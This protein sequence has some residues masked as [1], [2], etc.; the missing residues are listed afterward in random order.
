MNVWH[1]FSR[2]LLAALL[3]LLA[4]A[5]DVSA[6][7][8]AAGSPTICE[9]V[10]LP[11]STADGVRLEAAILD[12]T[13]DCS[14]EACL[15][16]S[17]HTYQLRNTSRGQGAYLQVGIPAAS[18]GGCREDPDVA[19]RDADGTEQ[20][21]LEGNAEYPTI[22]QVQLG[23]GGSRRLT[24]SY[25]RNL[26]STR[27][28]D[29][30]WRSARLGAWGAI[31]GVH[32]V[33][34]LPAALSDECLLDVQP[35]SAGFDGY[36]FSWSYES[37]S[38]LPDHGLTMLVPPLA[39]RLAAL[40]AA[41]SHAE[42]AHLLLS[43]R[44]EAAA[45]GRTVVTWDAEI[46]AALL[47]A[48]A[49]HPDDLAARLDLAEVYRQQAEGVPAGRLN[50]L[51]LAAQE[52]EEARRLAGDDPTILTALAGCYFQAALA[53]SEEADPRGALGYLRQAEALG[54]A[55]LL[56][57]FEQGEELFLRWALGLARQGQV[58]EAFAEVADRLSPET[59]DALLHYAPPVTGVRMRVELSP[60]VRSVTYDLRP[61]PP[62]AEATLGR[63]TAIA[64]ALQAEPGCDVEVLGD[65]AAVTL[66]LAVRFASLEEVAATNA[67]L[68]QALAGSG[69]LL[70][71]IVAA[72]LEGRVVEYGVSQRLFRDVFAYRE[73]VD[74]SAVHQAWLGEA[75]YA[76][77][78][79]VELNSISPAGERA[80]LEQQ[81]ALAALRE[82]KAI[83]A[84]VPLGAQMA[85]EIP[86]PE[87]DASVRPSWQVTWGEA[88][89]VR[90]VHAEWRWGRVAA[91]A[92]VVLML[93]AALL[94]APRRERAPE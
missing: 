77:W 9:P 16:R 14:A 72:P 38:D 80:R 12:A 13:L 65:E 15:L 5:P 69:D 29:W 50:Y 74:L 86:A 52:L 36:N 35:H 46:L 8:P 45:L 24:L 21:R 92:G 27:L 23:A 17:T 2:T 73:E 53:A 90:W 48:L 66:R 6:Q 42:E 26:G 91:V 81:L 93:G 59:M 3:F 28:L 19:L 25:E 54:G 56:P 4:A 76:G 55:R 40:R 44:A 22:W 39:E 78:R 63:L 71:A 31:D 7:E 57:G 88:R 60:G 10:L 33:L 83:W 37:P 41:G 34:A 82:Q 89:E 30:W 67:R 70:A 64:A 20:P 51:L 79:L 87:G 75:E 49:E 84:T 58:R 61:Y 32:V 85:L 11:V 43:A 18:A 94:I 1:A 47:A 62:V 68:C